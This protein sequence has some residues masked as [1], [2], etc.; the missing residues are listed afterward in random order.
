MLDGTSHLL[1]SIPPDA[2]GDPVLALHGASLAALVRDS[3]L[4][5]VGYLSTTGV[6]GDT[7]GDWVDET[8]PPQPSGA[9]QR[10]RLVAEQGWLELWKQAAVPVHIFRLAGIYGPGRSAIDAVR[11]GTARRIDKPD[12]LF[13]R[14]HVNDIV[15]VLRAS[16]ARPRPGAVYNVCDDEPAPGAAVVEHA[17]ALLGM[18]PPP[19]LPLEAA[20]LSPM[21][22]SFYTDSRRVR[23]R[24]IKQELGVALRYP[25]FRQGLAAILEAARMHPEKLLTEY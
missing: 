8:T 14:I 10:Q 19:L 9:R 21:A 20:G 3:G 18:T 17:C 6:Y 13:S 2:G 12:L 23:N 24:L 4:E 16:M 15:Q 25:D 11:A 7:G 1:L 5:W 22:A